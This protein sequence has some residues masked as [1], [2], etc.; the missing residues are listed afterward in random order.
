MLYDSREHRRRE[1]DDSDAQHAKWNEYERRKREIGEDEMDAH[2]YQIR[3][4]KLAQEM[5]I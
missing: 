1:R 2:D 5:G 4:M 3:V